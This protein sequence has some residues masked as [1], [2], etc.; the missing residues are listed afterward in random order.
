MLIKSLKNLLKKL[1]KKIGEGFYDLDSDVCGI[2]RGLNNGLPGQ[3]QQ[4]ILN[5]NQNNNSI[6]R[7]KCCV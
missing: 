1:I 4:V 2:K 3:Q 6:F 7:N 5:N